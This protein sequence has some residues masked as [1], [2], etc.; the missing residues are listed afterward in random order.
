MAFSH[1]KSALIALYRLRTLDAFKDKKLHAILI[2]LDFKGTFG[3]VWHPVVL[4][5]LH[6]RNGPSDIYH[7]KS[8]L[9]DPR[10]IF[11]SHAGEVSAG[12]TLDI[13]QGSPIRPLLWNLIIYGLLELPFPTDLFAQ[14]YADDTVVVIASP[15]RLELEA[16]TTITLNLISAR[17]HYNKVVIGVCKKSFI[18]I[19]MPPPSHCSH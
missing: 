17:A 9:A 8:F 6:S 14:A 10:V 2:A 12:P 19:R 11:R 7:L 13:P 16:K 3:N 15:D 4:H 18:F 5:F 1:G